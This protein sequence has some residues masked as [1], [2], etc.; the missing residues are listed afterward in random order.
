MKLNNIKMSLLEQ[1]MT[2]GEL[3]A[4]MQVDKNT[5]SAW[6]N[7]LRQPTLKKLYKIADAIGVPAPRLLKE[8]NPLT[9]TE[10]NGKA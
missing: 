5:V 3:A 4:K 9:Q 8:I 1:E 2:Q 7:N 10:T 6:A